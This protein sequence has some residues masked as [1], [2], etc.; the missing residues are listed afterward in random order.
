MYKQ[1]GSKFISFAYPVYD[2]NEINEIIQNIR[3]EYYKAQHHCF[4][5]KL[6][7]EGGRFRTYDDGE[8]HGT[9]GKP[10]LGQI[11]SKELSDILIIVVRYFG[12]ILLGSGGLV[13]AYK[14]AAFEALKHA[15]IIEKYHYEVFSLSFDYSDLDYI[16]KITNEL[17][18]EIS[19]YHYDLRC[20][21][22]IKIRKGFSDKFQN[23]LLKNKEIELAIVE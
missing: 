16:M 11:L 8:P 5:W 6:E 7:R 22:K 23:T 21:L 17:K 2:E 20:K 19:F 14:T 1:K 3:K 13:T 18:G 10:I 4:A 9:A 15:E 12:G